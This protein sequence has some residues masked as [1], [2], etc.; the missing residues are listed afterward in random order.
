MFCFIAVLIE[1]I[2]WQEIVLK[3]D[4]LN[5]ISVLNPIIRVIL[6]RFQTVLPVQL[7]LS[8]DEQVLLQMQVKSLKLNE[9]NNDNLNRAILLTSLSSL[10]LYS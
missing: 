6:R 4:A 2:L 10:S 3:H 1:Q 9:Q 7:C 5:F 8:L